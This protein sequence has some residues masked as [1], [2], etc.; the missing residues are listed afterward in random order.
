MLIL[1]VKKLQTSAAH[2]LSILCLRNKNICP[3]FLKGIYIPRQPR[4]TWSGG[5][6]AKYRLVSEKE[7]TQHMRSTIGRVFYKKK[8]TRHQSNNRMQPL[9]METKILKIASS[10]SI[11]MSSP[12]KVSVVKLNARKS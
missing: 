4:F 8:K 5:A 7:V 9:L 6:M 11:Y 10:V 3:F 2:G 1:H 12:G